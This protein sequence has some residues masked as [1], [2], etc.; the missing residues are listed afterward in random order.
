MGQENFDRDGHCER[1]EV[2]TW[3]A[4]N[5]FCLFCILFLVFYLYIVAAF[6]PGFSSYSCPLLISS[7]C[8]GFALRPKNSEYLAWSGLSLQAC[9]LWSCKNQA[10]WHKDPYCCMCHFFWYYNCCLF[11]VFCQNTGNAS[12]TITYM[13]PE[14]HK[15]GEMFHFS[16]TTD[17]YLNYLA[18]MMCRRYTRFVLTSQTNAMRL[19]VTN[20]CR[21]WKILHLSSGNPARAKTLLYEVERKS[22]SRSPAE[23]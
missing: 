11:I 2:F 13:A 20:H 21:N 7:F 17:I 3:P 12:G 10:S 14:L 18:F 1:N 23:R 4:G 6:T 5:L 15:S 8:I 22:L 16:A 19:R 9:R